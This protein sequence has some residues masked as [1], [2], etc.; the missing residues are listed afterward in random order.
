VSGG[1]A[2][3]PISATEGKG[4]FVQGA[5][6]FNNLR[7]QPWAGYEY[8][9]ANYPSGTWNAYRVGLTY[10]LKGHNANIKFGYER[11]NTKKDIGP[12]PTNTSSRD[13]INTFLLGFYVE[14]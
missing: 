3:H 9:E 4:H 5:Y 14:F 6:F 12:T 2:G 13:S 10:F 11:V 7:L 1:R 8:W